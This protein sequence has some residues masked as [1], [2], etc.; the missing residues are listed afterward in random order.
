MEFHE[1]LQELRKQ[2]NLTQEDLAAAL[3]VSRTAISKWE[4]G[5]GY[6]NIDSLRAIS[7]FFGVTI[8]DLL[9]GGELLILAEKDRQQ[10]ERHFRDL[11][12]GLLDCSAAMFCFLPFFRQSVSGVIQ[13]VSLSSLTEISVWSRTAY[14]AVT[15]G[16]SL[17]GLLTLVLQNCCQPV[18][19]RN[20]SRLSLM[21]TAAGAFLFIISL[22]PYAAAFLFIFLMIKV[23]LLTKKQ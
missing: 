14:L 12:F 9:S 15:I 3:F 18:W 17:Y 2:K 19:I 22:Q 13:A 20:K 10:T 5:R 16:I 1:K 21:L 6:P 11:V 8:D 23:L 7:T 4:S